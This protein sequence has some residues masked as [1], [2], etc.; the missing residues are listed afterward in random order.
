MS[1]VHCHMQSGSVPDSLL[2]ILRPKRDRSQSR[3]RG[4]GSRESL[5]CQ[6]N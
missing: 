2:F 1:G 3:P 4:Q 5:T 6:E